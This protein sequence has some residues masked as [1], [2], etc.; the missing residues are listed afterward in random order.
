M[1]VHR[2]R[3]SP[4]RPFHMNVRFTCTCTCT[5][6]C[7]CTWPTRT[8]TATPYVHMHMYMVHMYMHACTP[9]VRVPVCVPS[10]A[11]TPLCTHPVVMRVSRRWCPEHV[12]RDT[13][14]YMAAPCS[15][16]PTCPCSCATQ[17]TI[18][19]THPVCTRELPRAAC[20][21]RHALSSLS[22]STTSCPRLR[23]L[24]ARRSHPPPRL[25][26]LSNT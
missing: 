5:C 10:M 17:H 16:N 22:A 11:C 25:S 26:L 6:T 12:P 23:L 8:C 19:D 20:S 15:Y 13:R 1:G 3:P 18:H 24:P 21:C 14:L 2:W 9:F 4:E 7:I